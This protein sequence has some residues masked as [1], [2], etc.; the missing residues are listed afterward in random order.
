MSQQEK[1]TEVFIKNI[2][3]GKFSEVI[4]P[5][6]L[7]EFYRFIAQKGQKA[8]CFLLALQLN[9]N[10]LA[11]FCYQLDQPNFW[12]KVR[13]QIPIKLPPKVFTPTNDKEINRQK[14]EEYQNYPVWWLE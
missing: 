14:P 2:T 3:E 12:Q 13:R 6:K 4:Y 5:D 10:S 8:G 9:N 11:W 1:D 7:G